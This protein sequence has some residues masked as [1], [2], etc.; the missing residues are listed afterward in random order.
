[1]NR[2]SL[3]AGIVLAATIPGCLSQSAESDVSDDDDTE[4]CDIESGRWQGEGEPLTT[5]AELDPEDTDQ[6]DDR[7]IERTCAEIA[8]KAA[9]DELH[10]RLEVDLEGAPWADYG[11]RY[12]ADGATAWVRIVYTRDR[13]GSVHNCPESELEVSIARSALPAAVTVTLEGAELDE[14]YECTHEI[15]LQAGG[16]EF[17]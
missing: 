9:F 14:G 4:S 15:E 10:T 13:D 7:S 16:E 6:S 17:D 8:A 11:A 1:M 5:T 3:L 12:G 2:R